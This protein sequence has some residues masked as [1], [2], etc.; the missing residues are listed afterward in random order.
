MGQQISKRVMPRISK[1]IASHERVMAQDA[2]DDIA[3]KQAKAAAS[4]S[5]YSDPGAM[6]G[7]KRDE[8]SASD[9]L[10]SEL[11]QTQFLNQLHN[12]DSA[13]G[14]GMGVP[15]NVG[16]GNNNN[17]SDTLQEM[18]EDLVK[19]LNDAGPLQR[20]VD[21]DLTSPK[22]YESLLEEEE[23]RKQHLQQQ[24]QR[25]RRNMP[26]IGDANV[27]GEGLEN[28][29]ADGSTVSRTTNFSNVAV[30]DE[31]IYAL[32]DQDL[33]QL[34]A[35]LQNDAISPRDF[36]ENRTRMS[37]SQSQAEITDDS[38]SNNGDTDGS[39]E[40]DNQR[41][42]Q[43]EHI[44]LVEHMKNNTAVPILMQDTDKSFVGAW[45]DKREDLHLV[46]VKMAPDDVKLSFQYELELESAKQ[47]KK[48]SRGSPLI[49]DSSASPLSSQSPK[50]ISEDIVQEGAAAAE[51]KQNIGITEEE[52]SKLSEK[53][54]TA[55]FLRQARKEV[56][57]NK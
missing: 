28:P 27:D 22:V 31:N 10:P 48:I 40:S 51:A 25:R 12:R 46:G 5:K 56:S 17:K 7:F 32:G 42:L 44:S 39:G 8:W 35:N 11:N 33:F 50:S 36:V 4:N 9:S 43:Q 26:M 49:L 21:K 52:V 18:P 24:R 38:Q 53:T 41:Q 2:L 23:Q 29:A 14:M 6:Q 16:P 55:E 34:L 20:K 1:A 30:R 15:T 3:R 57:S 37:Q 13:G 47:K 54:S 19:F 45:N